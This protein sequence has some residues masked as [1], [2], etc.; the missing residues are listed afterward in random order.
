MGSEMPLPAANEANVA[1]VVD[2][3]ISKSGQCADAAPRL[4]N[5]DQ[6]LSGFGPDKN[7]RV[8]LE[9]RQCLEQAY[10]WRRQQDG[11][12]TCLGVW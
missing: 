8:A 11:F 7:K 1:Q 6:V 3:D 2:S 9:A 4:L 10:S 5:I 12:L